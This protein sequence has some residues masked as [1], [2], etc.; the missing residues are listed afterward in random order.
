[1]R[2]YCN[3]EIESHLV[4]E[5]TIF[6]IL[7]ERKLGPKLY[8][9][10]DGGRL[11]EYIESRSLTCEEISI[12]A[13]SAKIAI[14]LTKI[15]QLEV[16][17][18][19]EPDFLFDKLERWLNQLKV[20]ASGQKCFDLPTQYGEAVPATITCDDIEKELFYFKNKISTSSSY[21]V[22]FCHN[23]LSEGNILKHEVRSGGE[24]QPSLKDDGLSDRSTYYS[25]VYWLILIDFEYASYNYRGFDF[26]NHFTEWS[27]DYD[28]DEY[29][30]YKVN[31]EK[32]PSKDQMR[33]FFFS[34]IRQTEPGH[35]N[36]N[37]EA[38]KLYEET[39]PFVPIANFFW[40]VWGLLQ[41]EKSP[42]GG[43][44]YAESG[45]ERLALYFHYKHLIENSGEKQ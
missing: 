2:V 17:I 11:E 27:I 19:K 6:T 16:P 30:F 8:G 34:Y 33:N 26:A 7:S 13:K 1:L 25:I 29:P 5:T 24:Q 39:L 32:F 22:C 38:E 40:G 15:H 4:D 18:S 37:G 36:L 3:P 35:S 45:R 28:V 10:F 44:G 20:T 42:P 41:A 21:P 23:D 43:F 9:N 12:P 31:T 14:E